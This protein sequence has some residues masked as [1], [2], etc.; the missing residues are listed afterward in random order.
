MP[1]SASNLSRETLRGI[2]AA[3]ITPWNKDNELDEARFAEEIRA[4]EGTGIHGV[5]TGGTTGEFYAQDDETFRQITEI[6]CREGHAIGLPVQIG[7]T[8]LS[9][10][11]VRKRVATALAGG[12]DGIQVAIPF[13]LELKDDEVRAFLDDVV[14]AAEDTP[15]ILYH[16]PRAKRMLSPELIG[17]IAAEMPTFIGMKYPSVDAPTLRAILDLAPDLAVFVGESAL[18][19]MVKEGA[20]GCYSSVC[21]L[22]ARRMAELF[23]HA[24]AGRYRQAEPIHEAVRRLLD[25]VL[26]PMV[27]DEGLWDS[28]VDRVMRIAGGVGVGLN[29]QRPYRRATPEHVQRLRTWCAAEAPLLLSEGT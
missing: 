13:W 3:L 6:A 2:W 8:A 28:A 10:R 12:A 19:T 29:C 15:I 26:H 18:L 20:R 25:E 5:Y 7:C 21:G 4:Y 16:T 23:E 14:D 27:T 1:T 11:T 9:S 22:N 17:E 24:V